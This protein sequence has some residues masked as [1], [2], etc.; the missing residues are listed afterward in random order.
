MGRAYRSRL[1]N[2]TEAL[3]GDHQ[4]MYFVNRFKRFL[5]RKRAKPFKRFTIFKGRV[6]HRAEATV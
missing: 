3:A 5:V 1:I 4:A 6:Y 2:H